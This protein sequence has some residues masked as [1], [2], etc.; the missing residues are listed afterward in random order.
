M[1]KKRGGVVCNIRDMT[2]HKQTERLLRE[3]LLQSEELSQLK[4]NFVTMASHEFRT[5]LTTIL[6][7]SDIVAQ[8]Q[9]RLSNDKVKNHM[10]KIQREVDYLNNLIDD[11]LLIGR[12]NDEGF[13][14]DLSISK[15]SKI[16]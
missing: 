5:P 13:Y 3:A 8:Y 1:T 6:S 4:V 11:I 2:Q 12:S 15:S 16:D 14:S 7:S 10:L 9:H